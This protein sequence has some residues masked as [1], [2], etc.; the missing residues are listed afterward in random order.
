MIR[1]LRGI[2]R[3]RILRTIQAGAKRRVSGFLWTRCFLLLPTNI[4]YDQSI[5]EM[6]TVACSLC[7]I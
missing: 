7:C 2:A 1:I 3:L 6:A 4:D 5:T